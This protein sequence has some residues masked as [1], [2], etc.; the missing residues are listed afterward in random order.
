MSADSKVFFRP[1]FRGP[2]GACICFE[3][4]ASFA[5]VYDNFFS[6]FFEKRGTK[7]EKNVYSASDISRLFGRDR[8]GFV[9]FL[10]TQNW[11]EEATTPRDIKKRLEEIEVYP[12]I[13]DVLLASSNIDGYLKAA[14][15]EVCEI[16]EALSKQLTDVKNEA[17]L[18]VKRIE[19]LK[20]EIEVL[21]ETQR[22]YLN[23]QKQIL[24]KIGV[25]PA[26]IKSLFTGEVAEKLDAYNNQINQ[27]LAR[28]IPEDT[29]KAILANNSLKPQRN[30]LETIETTRE[31]ILR[32]GD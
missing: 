32:K 6:S 26:K 25:K 8:E 9:Q 31:S 11:K 16:P 12:E 4:P 20:G 17:E 15:G 19:K 18:N 3:N 21:E 5:K 30:K 23:Q 10:E 29:Q 27:R 14:E 7:R 28:G 22:T 1:P 13:M 2:L 24:K